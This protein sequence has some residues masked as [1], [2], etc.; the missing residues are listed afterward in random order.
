[1]LQVM[2]W[3]R[4]V[5]PNRSAGFKKTKE[6]NERSSVLR[7]SFSEMLWCLSNVLSLFSSSAREW[8][9]VLNLWWSIQREGFSILA[10]LLIKCVQSFNACDWVYGVFSKAFLCKGRFHIWP[11]CTSWIE[12]YVS[13]FCTFV[14]GWV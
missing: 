2:S 12:L 7:H 4:V 3:Q 6:G 14:S 10:T 8:Y 9:C 1:M 11:Y 5:K 13:F